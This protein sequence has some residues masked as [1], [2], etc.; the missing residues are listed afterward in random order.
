[1]SAPLLARPTDDAEP[2]ADLGLPLAECDRLMLDRAFRRRFEAAYRGAAD[3]RDA[4][5]WLAHPEEPGPSGADAPGTHLA[6]LRRLVYRED[7]APGAVGDLQR[8]LDRIERDRQA[9]AAAF[10]AAT[11]PEP[12][13]V[14]AADAARAGIRL[15][16]RLP[17]RV[18]L[19]VVLGAGAGAA[20]AAMP[21]SAGSAT[22]PAAPPFTVEVSSTAGLGILAR[23]ARSTDRPFALVG[24]DLPL[25]TFR[26][27]AA[28]ASARTVLYAARDRFGQVCLVAA[29]V[30]FHASCVDPDVWKRD[31]IVLV[32]S[33]GPTWPESATFARVAVWRPDGR[34]VAGTVSG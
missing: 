30:Y 32:W 15:L 1:M 16:R 28:D 26:R 10:R 24:T 18:L 20:L 14:R 19:A 4:L 23:P 9:A 2:A 29:D 7:P 25:R 31:G 5:W 17:R 12:H 34:F 13:P 6:G 8:A 22:S 21:V 33:S 3:P 27:L 11:G